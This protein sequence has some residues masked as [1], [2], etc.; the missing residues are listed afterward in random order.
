[1]GSVLNTVTDFVGLTDHEGE[2][3]A[4][5]MANKQMDISNKHKTK[6]SQ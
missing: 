1:M 3:A 4:R 6:I 5:D 2:Q